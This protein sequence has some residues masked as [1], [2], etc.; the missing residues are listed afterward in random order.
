[1][2]IGWTDGNLSFPLFYD[3]LMVGLGLGMLSPNLAFI[4]CYL[5]SLRRYWSFFVGT[6]DSCS[7]FLKHV[8][9]LVE[10][11]QSDIAELRPFRK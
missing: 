6:L 9:F 1:M 11:R 2:L 4:L 5:C 3:E 10:T 7:R 8:M